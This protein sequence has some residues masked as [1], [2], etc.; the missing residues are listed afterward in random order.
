MR[1][2][3]WSSD[4]CSS[5]LPPARLRAVG[6]AR[7]GGLGDQPDPGRWRGDGGASYQAGVRALRGEQEDIAG[8]PGIVRRNAHLHRYFSAMILPFSG[9]APRPS[10]ADPWPDHGQGAKNMLH[11]LQFGTGPTPDGVLRAMFAARK[12]VFVDLLK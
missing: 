8:D 11:T 7:Q 1:I 9:I 12:S 5:D 2:S 3:D 4:V 10:P 6:G